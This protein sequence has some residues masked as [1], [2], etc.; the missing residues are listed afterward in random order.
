MLFPPGSDF[1]YV[2][3]GYVLVG[4]A[5]EHLLDRPLADAYRSLIFDP[6]GM[7][8]TY[9]EWNE[10]A[11]GRDLHPVNMSYRWAGGGLVTTASDLVTFLRGLFGRTLFADRWV[12]EMTDWDAAVRW[13]P[14]ST[15]RYLR[16]GLGGWASTRRM[17]RTSSA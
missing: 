4:I 12:A 3:T 2:D 11:R 14:H 17:A 7:D 6:L 10:P 5:I 16:Y 8:D 1:A 13:R 9:L 15:A